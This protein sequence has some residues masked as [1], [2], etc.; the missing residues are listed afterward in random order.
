MKIARNMFGA[1]LLFSIALTGCQNNLSDNQDSRIETSES[2]VE[3]VSVKRGRLTP[4]LSANSVISTSLP[5]VITAPVKGEF[6]ANVSEGTEIKKDELIG[7]INGLE[8]TS[9]A[10]AT[11]ISV[12]DSAEVPQNYPLF[13]LQYTGFSINIEAD[14]FLNSIPSDATLNAKFQI[15]DGLGPENIMAVVLTSNSS[16]GEVDSAAFLQCLI[17]HEVEVKGGQNVTVVVTAE[18]KEN[19]LLLP[20]SAVAGRVKQG[21]VTIISDGEQKEVQVELGVSDGA[22]IEIISGLS[23]GDE[24]SAIPPNLDPRNN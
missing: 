9:P 15:K 1:I 19:V 20:V 4:T 8:I 12:V 6:R 18:S 23:E 7:T 22:Y 14:E 21:N 10:D 13:E 17:S 2:Q 11:V 3:T 5:F 16:N 24:V